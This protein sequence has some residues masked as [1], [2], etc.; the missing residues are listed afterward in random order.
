MSIS[1]GSSAIGNDAMRAYQQIKQR[2]EPAVEST[3]L[4]AEAQAHLEAKQDVADVINV[5]EVKAL[6]TEEQIL[7][8][9]ALE[10]SWGLISA[11]LGTQVDVFV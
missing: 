2:G 5:V 6:S 7:E 9:K 10:K 8:Q 4:S 3:R 1:M 11:I